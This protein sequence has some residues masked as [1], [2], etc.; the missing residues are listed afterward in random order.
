LENELCKLLLADGVTYVRWAFAGSDDDGGIVE[1]K[2]YDA[3]QVEKGCASIHSGMHPFGDLAEQLLQQGLRILY[4][5]N[6]AGFE[7]ND[8]GY[9]WML[10][11]VAT[12]EVW[13]INDYNERGM[14]AAYFDASRYNRLELSIPEEGLSL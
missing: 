12:N 1:V 5:K 3:N 6:L 14:E 9:G 13:T 2:L 10:W 7:N 4:E 11:C 8:G